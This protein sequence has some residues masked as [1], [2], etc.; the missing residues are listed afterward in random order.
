MEYYEPRMDPIAKYFIER[1]KILS[2]TD[3]YVEL[4]KN[5]PKGTESQSKK[6][7]HQQSLADYRHDQ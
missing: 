1:I 4:Q 3:K 7:P 6:W 2:M 5:R